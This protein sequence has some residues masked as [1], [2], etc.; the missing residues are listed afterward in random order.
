[1]KQYIVPHIMYPCRSRTKDKWRSCIMLAMVAIHITLTSSVISSLL[2]YINK[3]H[4]ESS[5]KIII[6]IPDNE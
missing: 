2:C 6:N 4:I 1:M 5:D 3:V